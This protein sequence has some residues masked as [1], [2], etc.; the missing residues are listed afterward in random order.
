MAT[1][2]Q[3]G[4]GEPP[5]VTPV[6]PWLSRQFPTILRYS[7]LLIAFYETFGEKADRPALLGLAGTM[8]IGAVT[9]EMIKGRR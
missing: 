6:E 2:P 7:G 3:N 4:T 9:V 8:M 1:P 5:A